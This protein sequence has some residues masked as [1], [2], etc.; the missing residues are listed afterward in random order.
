MPSPIITWIWLCAYLNAVGWALSACHALNKTGYAVAF[1]VGITGWLY[2]RHT[3]RAP[4]LPP[5]HLPC[6]KRRFRRPF[7]LAFLILA[8]MTF[9][10]GAMHGANNYDSLAY[11]TPRVLHWLDAGQWI[12]VH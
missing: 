11:R 6:L 5:I 12:W 3:I 8:G 2:W 1:A 7:P 10:G 9:L 4:W